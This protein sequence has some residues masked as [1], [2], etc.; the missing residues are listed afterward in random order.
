MVI[1]STELCKMLAIIIIMSN[2]IN[3]YDVTIPKNGIEATMSD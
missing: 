1:I 2:T 3:C